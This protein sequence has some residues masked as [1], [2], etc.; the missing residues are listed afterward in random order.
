MISIVS[1]SDNYFVRDDNIYR[2][3]YKWVDF[4]TWTAL[5]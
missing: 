1:V 3:I 2:E 5:L 4:L